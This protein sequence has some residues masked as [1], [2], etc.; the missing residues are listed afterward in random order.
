M[1]VGAGGAW[2]DMNAFNDE[3][4]QATGIT[5]ARTSLP[6]NEHYQKLVLSTVNPR[7]AY[8][9]AYFAYQWKY[10]IADVFAE[11]SKIESEVEG[12]PALQLDDYPGRI[13]DVYGRVGDKLIGLPMLGDVTMF[14]WDK[15]AYKAAGLDPEAAPKTWDEVFTRAQALTSGSQYGY[16]MPAGKD[17]QTTVTWI[18]L[19]RSMGGEYLSADGTPQFDSEASVNALKFMIEKL[20]TVSPP[21]NLTWGFPEMLGSFTSGESAQSMMWPGGMGS[22]MDPARST[23]ANVGYSP[24]PSVALLGGW[25]LGVDGRSK[26]VEAAKLYAAWISS[27]EIM[28]RGA[29]AGWAA[30]RRSVLSNPEVLAKTPYQKAV[31]EGLEGEVAEYPPVKQ[32]E[33]VH[34]MIFDE[35]NAA[36]SGVKSAEQAAADLQA[37]VVDFLKRHG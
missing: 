12:A 5:I 26:N 30:T 8:D 36:I 25:S 37:K 31:L 3:F 20:D 35:A 2:D 7:G 18:L 24:T 16:G 23:V 32:A 28:L 1:L 34:I 27:P 19:F 33:Q 4:T 22:V 15:D 14:I 6:Y 29:K 13:L 9:L 11:M 10:E 17:I 21:G